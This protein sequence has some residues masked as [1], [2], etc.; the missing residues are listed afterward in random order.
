VHLPTGGRTPA[1]AVALPA[2]PEPRRRLLSSG[3]L[4]FVVVAVL[5]YLGWSTQTGRY[6]NPNRGLGYALGIIGGSLMLLLLVYSLRK[7]WNWLAFLV[8]LG[9]YGRQCDRCHSTVSWK[10]A[11]VH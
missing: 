7:R 11:R 10:G 3:R 9:Q 5:L 4:F 8:H 6:I 2:E 1:P